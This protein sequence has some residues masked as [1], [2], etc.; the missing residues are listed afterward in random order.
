MLKLANAYQAFGIEEAKPKPVWAAVL[1]ALLFG[2]LGLAYSSMIGAG[3]MCIVAIALRICFGSLA[4][5]IVVP[6][7]VLWAWWATRE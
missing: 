6:V 1:Y 5:L 4:T 7:C 2:P 3:V